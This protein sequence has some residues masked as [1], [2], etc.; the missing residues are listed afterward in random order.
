MNDIT[1]FSVV[2]AVTLINICISVLVCLY[3]KKVMMKLS[4]CAVN[5]ILYILDQIDNRFNRMETDI[6]TYKNELDT[7]YSRI[8]DAF[9]NE[10]N[11]VS[12][13]TLLKLK[14]KIESLK[15]IARNTS[16]L[17]FVKP[18][19]ENDN[20]IYVKDKSI[21]AFIKETNIESLFP[22]SMSELYNYYVKFTTGTQNTWK[23]GI[24]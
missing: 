20:I 24:M 6:F 5:Q 23:I 18:K 21:D 1:I 22:R 12:D 2:V 10:N 13:N 9:F 4:D 19:S 7:K 16:V 3:I 8:Y 17:D 15:N 11:L 14:S